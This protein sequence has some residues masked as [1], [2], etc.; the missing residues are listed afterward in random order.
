MYSLMLCSDL[1]L[2]V[3]KI[4]EDKLEKNGVKYPIENK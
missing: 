2:D 3:K 1:E 4:V